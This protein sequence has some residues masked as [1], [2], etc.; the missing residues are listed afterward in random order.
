M[1]KMYAILAVLVAFNTAGFASC[2]LVSE[3]ET[4]KEVV[5]DV[6]SEDNEEVNS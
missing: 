4:T 5:V 1:K 3:T 2:E 6:D